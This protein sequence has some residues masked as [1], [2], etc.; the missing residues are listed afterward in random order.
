MELCNANCTW[1]KSATIPLYPYDAGTDSGISYMSHRSSTIPAAP[2]RALRPDW[3]RDVRSPFFNSDGEIRPFARLRMTRL[4][5]YEKSCDATDSDGADRLHEALGNTG[6][7]GGGACATHTWSL[8]G[9]CSVSCGPGRTTRQR[10][11]VWPS[12]A[13]AEACRV[14]LTDYKR[15][16]G[17]RRHCR[18]PSEYEP[19]PA[20][21]TGPCA[22]STWSEWSPCEGCGVRARTRHYV[23]NRAYKRCHIGYRARTILSQ[24]MPCE[25][26]PCEKPTG[27]RTNNATNFDWFFVDMTRGDC[28]VTSWGSWSPCSAKCGRGHRLRTRLYTS[29]DSKVQQELSKRLLAQWN[30]RFAQFQ[31]IEYPIDNMTAED[32][33]VETAVQEHMERCQFTLTQQESLCDG[34]D[35]SC[36]NKTVPTEVCKLPMSVGHCRGYE[37]RWFY[38]WAQGVC[39]PFGFSGCGGNGNNFRTRDHCLQACRT[40]KNNTTNTKN[41]HELEGK[42][43]KATLSKEVN[44]VVQNDIP[45]LYVEA[46]CEVGPWLGW[47]ECFGD[48]EY[49][50]KLNYRLILNMITGKG[51]GCRRL[52]KSRHCRPAHCHNINSTDVVEEFTYYSD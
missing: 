39:E 48:C 4:R 40:I 7:G 21:S 37:E 30:R 46:N 35:I 36:L 26:G 34:E 41:S 42:K 1:S 28:P 11:Y 52:I 43:L 5:L 27:N 23:N 20:E 18:A 25:M 15:C 2:V 16:H 51:K 10:N 17:P 6:I 44:E 3:P 45:A 29:H 19:D 24:A 49:A 13:Y 33:A 38:E 12:R 47:T 8:W 22:V 9:P 50:V 32:P 31:S 14:P